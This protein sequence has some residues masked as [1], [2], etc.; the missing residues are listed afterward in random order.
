INPSGSL[1]ASLSSPH[2]CFSSLMHSFNH[3]VLARNT[4]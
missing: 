4:T 1:S 3:K 2:L